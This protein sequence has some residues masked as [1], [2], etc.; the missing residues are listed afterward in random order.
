[1]G[2]D[3]RRCYLAVISGLPRTRQGIYFFPLLV[4]NTLKEK[5]MSAPKHS[6]TIPFGPSAPQLTLKNLRDQFWADVYGKEVQTTAT[7]SYTWVADQFGHICLGLI[8]NFA[9][10]ALC[11]VV[12]TFLGW[13][14]E[15]HYDTGKWPGLVI[16]SVGAALWEWFAYKKSVDEATKRFP[17]DT[18]LLRDNAQVAAGYMIL[19]GVLG[20]AFHL[21]LM[22][23]L[24][25]SAVVLVVAILLAPKWLRQKIIWQKAALPY[26]FRLAD[27]LPTV[28]QPDA[29]TLQGLIN[30]GAPPDTP[31]CQIV[32]GGP[33]GA[34]RTSMAAGIGTEFAFKN[35][36]VRYL[37]LDAL[38]E[39]A[40]NSTKTHF[41]N[42][43]GPTTIS[44][45]PWSEAQVVIID[46]IG[47]MLAV[48]DPGRQ[49]NFS[50]FK[51]MLDTNLINVVEV[52]K[53][54]HTV[55]VI[56]DLCPPPPSDQL[57]KIIEEFAKA[58]AAY[59]QSNS[60]PFV[61][62]LDAAPEPPTAKGPIFPSTRAAPHVAQLR[63]IYQVS[64]S[65]PAKPPDKQ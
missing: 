60:K 54:C 26:L 19:G 17:L 33:I 39:F 43:R 51:A 52:L 48:D 41:P 7:Y 1:V 38:L 2:I 10:T 24:I 21:H 9:A 16:V 6:A 61:I 56:G 44:Y 20:F 64:T 47:P 31:P 32:I 4:R 55:W 36:K 5:A 42:D 23:A 14:H 35:Q 34:G 18:A 13:S 28:D 63:R 53:R 62:Q 57:G 37:S 12:M 49:P 65:T 40:V 25:V 46:G 45:W 50:R 30:R 58:V 3:K 11:G 59:C 15:F 8:G 29:D 27:V 22:W